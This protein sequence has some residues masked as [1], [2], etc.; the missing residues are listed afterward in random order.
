[1][2]Q[3]TL[4]LNAFK[5]IDIETDNLL[6]K[7]QV[8]PRLTRMNGEQIDIVPKAEFIG[9]GTRILNLLKRIFGEDS[10]H[11]QEFM[12]TFSKSYGEIN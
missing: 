4:I 1:M 3:E 6:S 8:H 10:V 5:E 2:R 7:K 11:Y 9:W 12:K